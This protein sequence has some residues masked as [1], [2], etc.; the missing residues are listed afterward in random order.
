M[1][2]SRTLALHATLPQRYARFHVLASTIDHRGRLLAL[3]VDPDQDGAPDLPLFDA[4][5]L[6]CDGDDEHRIALHD[7]DQRFDAIDSQGDGVVLGARRIPGANRPGRQ[8]HSVPALTRNVVA[9]DGD[10]T[11][12]GA[13]YAGDGIAQMLT[14]PDGRIW[15]SYFDE[16]TYR[17][18]KP[19]GTW[20]ESFMIGLARWD[21]PGGD[22]WFAYNDTGRAVDWCDC[23]AMNV[24]RELVHAC[25]YTEFPV[26]EIDANGVR[27]I[28]PNSIT[29]CSGLA[30]SGSALAF[31]D[32]HRHNDTP[33]WMI[34]KARR[35]DGAVIET[36][37]DILTL[38]DG[39]SPGAWARGKVGRDAMLFLHEEGDP[40]RWYR[41]EIG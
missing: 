15:I 29:G 27:S 17:F 39:R 23:Y 10:G 9:F 11:R 14:D 5:V 8:Q 28:T 13:F 38:P 25:P 24:G 1:A 16:A 7:L 36:G 34:R 12:T 35:A 19:D 40:R 32:Q 3:L 33:V 37:Q 22:P 30:V 41:Y 31:L 2:D 21:D 6:I 20:A 4:T 18:A 26:V